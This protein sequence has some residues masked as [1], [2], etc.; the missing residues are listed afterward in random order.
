MPRPG[1]ARVCVRAPLGRVG[2]AGLPGAFWCASPFPVIVLSFFFVWP[3]QAGV[4][5]ALGV[6]YFLFFSLPFAPP[7]RVPAVSGFLCFPALGA[8]GLGALC[9]CSVLPPSSCFF[10]SLFFLLCSPSYNLPALLSAVAFGALG[11]GALLCAPPPIFCPPFFHFFLYFSS[12][13]VPFLCPLFAPLLS[14][15]FRCFR[16]W[17]P[18]AVVGPAWPRGSPPCCVLCVV[19]AS[20]S[21]VLCPVFCGSVLPCGGML[22]CP[23]VRLALFCGPCG[24]VLLLGAVSGAL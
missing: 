5:R 6:F 11:L 4:A 8:L 22:R 12:S 3:P 23:T 24:A 2:W 20:R 1:P 9:F 13:V 17:V 10:S 21:S 16:P 14:R 18:W 19:V 15:R 7:P